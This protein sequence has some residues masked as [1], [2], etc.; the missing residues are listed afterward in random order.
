MLKGEDV[1]MKEAKVKQTKFWVLLG[2]I[3]GIPAVLVGLFIYS[4]K[5]KQEQ[6]ANSFGALGGGSLF[7]GNTQKGGFGE[8]QTQSSIFGIFRRNNT[9]D[10][11]T[12]QNTRITNNPLFN[13]FGIKRQTTI[14]QSQDQTKTT[15]QMPKDDIISTEAKANT[16]VRDH[17]DIKEQYKQDID[18]INNEM[19]QNRT[20]LASAPENTS[21]IITSMGTQ[22]IETT[23]INASESQTKQDYIA[24]LKDKYK[25]MYGILWTLNPILVARFKTDVSNWEQKTSERT[26]NVEKLN[27]QQHTLSG[28]M[29]SGSQ[30]LS[31]STSA[32]GV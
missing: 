4:R 22:T 23:V 29:D 25:Q 27:T 3:I 5:K 10:Q 18:P 1:R 15:A 13:L 31:S 14:S 16:N 32:T 11:T 2:V 19:D 17:Y 24:N 28:Y 12:T 8:D 26:Q 7:G 20:I 9:T 6:R 21:H 30:T